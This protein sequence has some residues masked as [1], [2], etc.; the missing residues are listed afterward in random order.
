MPATVPS[1]PEPVLAEI[2]GHVCKHS[3]ASE[4]VSL[5]LVCLAARDIVASSWKDHAESEWGPLDWETYFR[6]GHSL[7]MAELGSSHWGA[8]RAMLASELRPKMHRAVRKVS[9]R[10]SDLTP[11]ALRPSTG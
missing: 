8:L 5:S 11:S 1:L 3:T 9:S 7:E 6:V 2:F 10:L 4:R